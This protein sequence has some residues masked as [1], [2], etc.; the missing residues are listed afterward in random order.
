LFSACL[1]V[2]PGFVLL[3]GLA[4]RLY[5]GAAR[6]ALQEGR[7]APLGFERIAVEKLHID[8]PDPRPDRAAPTRFILWTGSLTGRISAGLLA[9]IV[10]F[11]FSFQIVVGQFLKF[12][13]NPFKGWINQPLVQM[14]W[15]D[16]AP[17]SLKKAAREE[18]RSN[19][20]R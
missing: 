20:T 2:F 9:L 19:A 12:E 16:L 4:A 1:F 14:P 3:H 11:A 8:V 18:R 7:L 5:A 6:E 13:S 15:F 17:Q 10:W